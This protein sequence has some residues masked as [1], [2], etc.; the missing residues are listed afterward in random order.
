MT[1][2]FDAF[3]RALRDLFSLRVL[4]VVVWPMLL[5]MLLW[6]VLGATFWSTFSGWIAQGLDAIGIQAW[7]ASNRCGLPTASRRCCI[8]CCSCRW[9]C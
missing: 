8:S 1:A 7:L 2:V 6:L 4:W 5:A 9:C 3:V